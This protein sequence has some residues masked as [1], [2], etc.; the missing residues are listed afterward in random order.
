M[1]RS[2]APWRDLP[3]RYGASLHDLLKPLGPLAQSR[4]LGSDHEC[5]YKA[6]R[7]D[8]PMMEGYEHAG[9]S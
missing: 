8:V 7:G 6:Y 1:L 4:R 3:E 2:G 9:H 5:D